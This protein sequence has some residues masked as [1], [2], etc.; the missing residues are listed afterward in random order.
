MTSRTVVLLTLFSIASCS[1]GKEAALNGDAC[2]VP[3]TLIRIP[4]TYE[5]A[6]ILAFSVSG[7]LL[8]SQ[9]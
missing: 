4:T 8:Q 5:L 3:L 1:D 6:A 9:S 2:A 7:A